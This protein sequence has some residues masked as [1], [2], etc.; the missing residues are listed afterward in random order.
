[1]INIEKK[2]SENIRKLVICKR[3]KLIRRIVEKLMRIG[4]SKK[5]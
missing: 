4:K 3:R 1:M 2:V 5:D